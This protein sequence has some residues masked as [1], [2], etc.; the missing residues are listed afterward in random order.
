MKSNKEQIASRIADAAI[1]DDPRIPLD[2][3]QTSKLI[4][5]SVHSLR[6]DRWAGG[7]VQ[8]IKLNGAIRYRRNDIDKYLVDRL[9]SSTSD[10]GAGH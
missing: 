9:R 7:G 5:R 2:E 4:N 6:R 3:F 1:P 8:Y 10:S